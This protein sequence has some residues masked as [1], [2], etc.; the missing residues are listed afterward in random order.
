M[1]KIILFI[2][3]CFCVS[4]V[5][6]Q[7]A[8]QLKNEG[9]AALKSKDY[10]TAMEKYEAFLG[11]EDTVEDI[12]LVFNTA[13]CASKIKD[14]AKAEKYFAQSVVNKYKPSKA[15]QY[16]AL[17][18]K[19]Q[20]KV[21]EMV[22]TLQKGIKACPTKNSK[23]VASLAKHYF[24]VGQTAQKG[25]KFEAAET[26]YKQAAQIKSKYQETAMLALAQLYYNKGAE[27]WPANQDKAK[28]YFEMATAQANKLLALNPAKKEAKDL[29]TTIKG[30]LK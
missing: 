21:S 6:A 18:Q 14:Y 25:N 4:S 28:S 19:K 24:S 2:A 7:S 27:F 17:M 13:Y 29:I 22:A 23:L 15:Y 9:N 8:A 26:S 1:K 20:N 12:A 5:F 11:A 16:L 10:K 30:L 3:V